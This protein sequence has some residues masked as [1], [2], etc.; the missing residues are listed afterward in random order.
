MALYFMTMGLTAYFGCKILNMV[1]KADHNSVDRMLNKL[2]KIQ[3]SKKS[4]N[5]DCLGYRI[6]HSC[7]HLK[8]AQTV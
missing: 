6:K 3:D 7:R 5:C 1:E 2:F 8:V 4:N